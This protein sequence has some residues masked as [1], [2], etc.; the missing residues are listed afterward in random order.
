MKARLTELSGDP[1]VALAIYRSLLEK[2]GS[3]Y[4]F[5]GE[6]LEAVDRLDGAAGN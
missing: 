3:G 2:A 5:S 6:L 4:T 1:A